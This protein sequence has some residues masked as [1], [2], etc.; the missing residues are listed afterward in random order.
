[1][2]Q[3]HIVGIL[4]SRALLLALALIGTAQ[5]IRAQLPPPPIVGGWQ[6]VDHPDQDPEVRAAAQALVGQLPLRHHRLRAVET[7]QRQ[8][9]AGTN[10]RLVV[11]VAGHGRWSA[12][13]WHRL[14]GTYAVADVLRI[15]SRTW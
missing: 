2:A 15:R 8:V 11:R 10:F 13:V 14:D 7:A 9:V 3:Q 1:M 4:R 12:V 5:P 6:V